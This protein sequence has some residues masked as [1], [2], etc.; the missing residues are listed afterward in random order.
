MPEQ[1]WSGTDFL[2]TVSGPAERFPPLRVLFLAHRVAASGR[3]M[4][5]SGARE[6]VIHL[7][8]GRVIS[9]SGFPGLLEG[10][11]VQGEPEDDMVRLI[12]RAIAAGQSPERAIEVAVEGLARALGG[13]ADLR[14]PAVRFERGAAEPA[15]RMPIS[16]PLPRLIARGLRMTRSMDQL[17]AMAAPRL[18]SPVRLQLPDDSPE[19]RWGLDPVCSRLLREAARG[20]T[21]GELLGLGAASE[22]LLAFDLLHQ[23]GLL[24]VEG[25]GLAS[26]PGVATQSRPPEARTADP[27]SVSPSSASPSSVSSRSVAPASMPPRSVAP[28]SVP[29]RSVAPAAAPARTPPGPEAEQARALREALAAMEGAEPAQILGITRSADLTEPGVEKAFRDASVRFHPDRHHNATG[30]VKDLAARAFARISDAYATL[31]DAGV[32]TEAQARMKAREEGRVYVSEADQRLAR[33]AFARG[34]IAFKARRFAESLPDVELAMRK[35]PTVWRY[36]ALRAQAACLAGQL[37]GK[38]ADA[39]LEAL[40]EKVPAGA[41]KAD[42]LYAMG[43]LLVRDGLEPAADARF[44]Q[45]LKENPEHVGAKR[46][47]WLKKRRNEESEAAKP[48]LLSG[49]LGKKS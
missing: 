33:V 19:Q 48:G 40:L 32:R 49:L 10:L 37:T 2:D 18:R 29:P 13:W 34:E 22:A 46:R 1:P 28:A 42:L 7:Q 9:V 26:R 14:G 23:L 6:R 15:S 41:A 45:A 39:A 21:L 24:Q 47:I 38:Q 20:G 3:L 36:G 44:A 31:R 17:R 8:A 5:L 4:V 35:D 43:E 11:G 12:G 27:R 25:G 30:E 16:E